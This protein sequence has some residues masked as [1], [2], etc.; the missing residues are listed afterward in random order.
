MFLRQK[1]K[2][3]YRKLVQ[4]QLFPTINFKDCVKGSSIEVVKAY[5]YNQSQVETLIIP[6]LNWIILTLATLSLLVVLEK[7]KKMNDFLFIP[8]AVTGIAFTC[9]FIISLLLF[10][11]YLYLTHVHVE[12]PSNEL[13]LPE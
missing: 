1:M 2:L 3:K 12:L 8:Y 4:E 5:E 9:T 6:I 7:Y 10:V 13:E 11:G